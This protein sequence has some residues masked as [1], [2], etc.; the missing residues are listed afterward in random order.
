MGERNDAVT[1]RKRQNT[2]T[3]LYLY[4]I[5]S[6]GFAAFQSC[7]LPTY[8][9]L[10]LLFSMA[11][12]HLSNIFQAFCF[13]WKLFKNPPWPSFHLLSFFLYLIFLSIL[14]ITV[15]FTFLSSCTVSNPLECKYLLENFVSRI[16]AFIRLFHFFE[17]SSMFWLICNCT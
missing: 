17:L 16:M 9:F 15:M 13:Y 7:L 10:I 12:Y 1:F 4:L 3:N 14:S 6:T 8:P 11:L 2:H 5:F